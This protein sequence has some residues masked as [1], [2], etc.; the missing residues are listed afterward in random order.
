MIGQREMRE[1]IQDVAN[2]ILLQVADPAEEM[3]RRRD[4]GENPLEL[5]REMVGLADRE[6]L[7]DALGRLR[8]SVGIKDEAIREFWNRLSDLDIVNEEGAQ[9]DEGYAVHIGLIIGARAQQLASEH[10]P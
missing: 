4:A 3:E 8:E 9:D 5:L 2:F 7:A 1:A 6:A 10:S